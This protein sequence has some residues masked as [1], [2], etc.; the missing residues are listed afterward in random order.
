MVCE[1]YLF[2]RIVFWVCDGTKKKSARSV[3]VGSSSC[4]RVSSN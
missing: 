4:G 2:I 1:G 3:E